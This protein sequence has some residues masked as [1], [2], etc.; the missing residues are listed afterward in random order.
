MASRKRFFTA[1]YNQPR[2]IL[3]RG[4]TSFVPGTGM[5]PWQTA[6]FVKKVTLNAA[7]GKFGAPS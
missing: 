4:G 5:C 2:L 1:H 6:R 7:Y 3:R